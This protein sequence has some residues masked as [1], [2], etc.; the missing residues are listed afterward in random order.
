M[1]R[2][3]I[4]EDHPELASLM[5]AAAESR[6]H[7]ATAVHTGEAALALLRPAA[8]QAAVV[9][10]LLPDMRGSAVLSALREQAIPAIAVSGVFKGD[11][12][13]REATE[14]HG[15]RAFFEKPFELLHLLESVEQLC[16]LIASPPPPPFDDEDEVVVFEDASLLDMEDEPGFSAEGD[17]PMFASQA[18]DSPPVVEGLT[19]AEDEDEVVV[20]LEEEAPAEGSALPRPST[21]E[22]AWEENALEGLEP[23]P[24]DEPSDAPITLK[25]VDLDD[26]GGLVALEELRPV[27][28]PPPVEESPEE[29]AALDA[30]GPSEEPPPPPE[31]PAEAA[32]STSIEVSPEEAAALDALGPSEEPPSP[33]EATAEGTPS[34][35]IE[36]SP[37]EAAAL[38]ALSPR[39]GPPAASETPTPPP[40]PD[41]TGRMDGADEAAALEALG[42]P[43]EETPAEPAAGPVPDEPEPG[44]ALPF[45]DREKVWTKAAQPN[46][47]RRTPPDWSLSGDLRN[48]SVPRLLNAYY[49]ARHSGELK[50]RQGSLQKVVYFEAGRPVYAA[51]NVGPERFLRFSVRRGA[52][53]EEQGRRAATLAREQ[54]LRSSEA[55][56]RLGLMDGPRREAL[57][58]EQVKEILGSML[59]WSEG[60]YGF[61]PMRPPRAGLV[62]LS[63]FPG[64]LILEGTLRAENLVGLR[65][66]MPR[67]RRLFP[68]AA[69]PY[70]LHELTLQGP[71]ALLL[72]YADGSKTVED[73]LTLTDM[74]ERDV[75]A[76]L[77]GLELI[78]V[79][80]ERRDEPNSRS[81]ISFGL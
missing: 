6:G 70:G 64:D 49:E 9:D 38:D 23:P 27:A 39:E 72:A 58:V 16:G 1:A 3:L 26:L 13:A 69:P 18:E 50:L 61:S 10:L 74:P 71:Q 52:V 4:V 21:A 14:V 44:I 43:P 32:P 59:T 11:R 41:D 67:S 53:T 35:S 15:A 22:I 46:T 55:L 28:V 75:L 78:G 2:L 8:F 24:P 5:V 77:R 81:R 36:V 68:S 76:T 54:N 12:F 79:L 42:P 66:R 31:A 48:T 19:L 80:E 73:L 37:E 17:E 60:A 56:L 20:S 62:K 33:L 25:T 57:L 51:S 34:P 45:G 65:Q 7:E 47:P 40:A 29:F 30:L 63:V